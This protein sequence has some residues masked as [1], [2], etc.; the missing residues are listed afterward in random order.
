MQLQS[1]VFI[2]LLAL[3]QITSAIPRPVIK[4]RPQSPLEIL[5]NDPY[6]KEWRDP[7]D[8]KVD[9]VTKKLNPLPFRNGEGATILGPQN[10][11]R[12]RQNPDLIRPP[13]TDHGDMNNM[14]WSF[15]DSH[16]RIEVTRFLWPIQ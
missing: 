16:V 3:L 4:Y 5:Q 15:A 14:R 8:S 12:Q 1:L 13:S 9:S 6:T 2:S 10:V 7:W 11:E